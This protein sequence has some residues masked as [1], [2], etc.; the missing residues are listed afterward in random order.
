[1]FRFVSTTGVKRR[2]WRRSTRDFIASRGFI[3]R[4]LAASTEEKFYEETVFIHIFAFVGRTDRGPSGYDQESTQPAT[5]ASWNESCA[6]SPTV[7]TWLQGRRQSA[8][9]A[10]GQRPSSSSERQFPQISGQRASAEVVSS[11]PLFRGVSGVSLFCVPW[12]LR[13]SFLVAISGRIHRIAADDSTLG[14]PYGIAVGEFLSEGK[15]G[16]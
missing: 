16:A 3:Q 6:E 15:V 8:T 7:A 2:C 10:S 12:R 1:M 4:G 13:D 11:I 14:K 9:V 5:I